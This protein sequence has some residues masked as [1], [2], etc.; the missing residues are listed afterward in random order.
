MFHVWRTQFVLQQVD[1]SRPENRLW[2][3]QYRWDIPVFHLDGVF[4]MKHRVD[5]VLL[6]QLLQQAEARTTSTQ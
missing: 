6:E 5:V 1:I 2:W 3:D 4:V